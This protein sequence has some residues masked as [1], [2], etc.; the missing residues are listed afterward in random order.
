MFKVLITTSGTGSRL[1]KFTDNTNKSLISVKGRYVI[2]YI[3]ELYPNSVELVIT[4]GYFGDKV[5][6]YI[7]KKYPDRNITFINVTPYEGKGSS[8]GYSMLQAREHLQCPFIFHCNDTIVRGNIPSP[9][10]NNWDGVSLGNDTETFNTHSFSSVLITDKE[11]TTMQ[12]KDAPRADALHIGLVGIKD[13][14]DFWRILNT[15]Y[16]DNPQDNTLNDC[17]V[18]IR[19]LKIGKIFHPVFFNHWYDTGNLKN[20]ENAKKSL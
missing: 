7:S 13:Y 17:A 3:I 19:M 1:Q 18:I 12:L 15:L 8:L 2:D 6:E 20:L 9:E 16:R 10:K 5:Q 4:L 11:I 14:Q